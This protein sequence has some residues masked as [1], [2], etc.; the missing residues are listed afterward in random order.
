MHTV[1]W[2]FFVLKADFDSVVLEW[3]LKFDL[4]EK[5][6]AICWPLNLNLGGKEMDMC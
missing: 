4:S 1:H 5:L 3:D 6:P 2:I